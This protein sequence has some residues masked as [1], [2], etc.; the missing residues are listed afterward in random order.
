M[1]NTG[2]AT[3]VLL[4]LCAA[5]STT[6]AVLCAV[7]DVPA[8]TLLIPY[9]EVDPVCTESSRNTRFTITNTDHPPVLARVVVWTNAGVVALYFDVYL[10]GYDQ[11]EVNLRRVLCDG[12]LPST[13]EA[14][15][16]GPGRHSSTAAHFTGCN[17]TA[18]PP[19]SPVYGGDGALTANQRLQ[20][21]ALLTGQPVP[22][23]PTLC[24]GLPNGRDTA[25]GYVTVDVVN[26]CNAALPG[27]V[28][29]GS[30]LAADNVLIGS[31]VLADSAENVSV[32][33]PVIPLEATTDTVLDQSPSFYAAPG[34]PAGPRREPLPSA[35]MAEAGAGSYQRVDLVA[36]RAPPESG[37]LFACPSGPAWFPLQLDNRSGYGS[38]GVFHVRDNG[39]AV[40]TS[41]LNPLPRMAQR[42][43]AQEEFPE[44]ADVAGGFSWLNLSH[45]NGLNLY[46]AQAWVGTIRQQTGRYAVLHP[47]APIGDA[48]DAPAFDNESPG[49]LQTFAG[50]GS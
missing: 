47:G 16:P 26:R 39:Q 30:H 23:N 38:R 27:D 15:A 43:A 40:P 36:W 4:A 45:G 20:L 50:D 42:T 6:Q 31:A 19:A 41:R 8:A 48:C 33:M 3:C 29:F 14:V 18:T 17:A 11:Q 32:T 2:I 35:W 34:L 28:E 49:P 46:P 10:N 1:R 37:A 13:G 7:D 44:L 24:A 5:P 12:W 25:E 22:S 9:F 21:R